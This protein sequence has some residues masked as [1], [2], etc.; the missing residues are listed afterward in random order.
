M[1]THP[2]VASYIRALATDTDTR[3]IH[4]H[5]VNGCVVRAS[6]ALLDGSPD[7]VRLNRGDSNGDTVVNKGLRSGAEGLLWGGIERGTEERDGWH[8]CVSF[9]GK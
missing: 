8:S 1:H 3:W 9:A 4:G 6:G 7:E 5:T 2:A